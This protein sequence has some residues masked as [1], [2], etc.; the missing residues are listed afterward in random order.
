MLLSMVSG[1][2]NGILLNEVFLIIA[3]TKP[4]YMGYM[5]MHE[6]GP[7]TYPKHDF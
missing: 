5:V 4:N 3:K 7:Q 2:D 1:N 6:I